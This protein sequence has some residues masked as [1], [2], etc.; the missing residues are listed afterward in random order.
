MLS[1]LLQISS[2]RQSQCTVIPEIYFGN[3]I[4]FL[5]MN[6]LV[7]RCVLIKVLPACES[8]SASKIT[9]LY[10]CITDKLYWKT[11]FSMHI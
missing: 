1:V 6:N 4:I 9:R 2:L 3:I 8:E 10:Y 7:S 11:F 5:T